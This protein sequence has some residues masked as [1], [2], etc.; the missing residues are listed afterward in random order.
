[1]QLA[2][3]SAENGR[4]QAARTGQGRSC[5]TGAF[6][7]QAGGG[8]SITAQQGLLGQ[9]IQQETGTT[10]AAVFSGT[11]SRETDNPF[12]AC[13]SCAH[14]NGFIS[15]H[16]P[17]G[18]RRRPLAQPLSSSCHQASLASPGA[19]S[20][21][22]QAAMPRGDQRALRGRDKHFGNPPFGPAFAPFGDK[23]LGR[24]KGG[25]FHADSGQVAGSASIAGSSTK[26][27]PPQLRGSSPSG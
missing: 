4:L 26:T 24:L 23:F 20:L 22:A 9:K 8:F 1:V 11:L 14:G 5:Q 6:V 7:Q 16:S 18:C 27:S 10:A 21:P 25:S 19:G 3:A 12:N 15:K 13:A 2:Q 17:S